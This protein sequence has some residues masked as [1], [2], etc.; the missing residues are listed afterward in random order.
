MFSFIDINKKQNILV[1]MGFK[2]RW[3]NLS[4]PEKAER[5]RLVNMRRF[6]L[7]SYKSS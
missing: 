1:K 5:Q 4:I 2:V 7:F 6:L 3:K